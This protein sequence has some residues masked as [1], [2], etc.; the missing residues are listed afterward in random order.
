MGFE[1]YIKKQKGRN[2]ICGDFSLDYLETLNNPDIYFN[3][4]YVSK[5]ESETLYGF[6]KHLPWNISLEDEAFSALLKLWKEWLEYE[7]IGLK[8]NTG[9]R[10]YV[11]FLKL[12][13]E[14]LFKIGKTKKEPII[15]KTQIEIK[16]KIQL[17]IYNWIYLENYSLV[18]AELKRAFKKY[19]IQKEWYK[20]EHYG[21][22]KDKNEY[23]LEIDESLEVYAK[24][25]NNFK[26]YK[27]ID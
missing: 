3:T 12:R 7:H 27:N 26:I 20:L 13:G 23:C 5:I 17:Y 9:E 21:V 8:F 14:N 6:Y 25:D 2:D 22:A 19:Q 24:T 15:R 11:Y 16:E 4:G 10:G 1:S 18:E